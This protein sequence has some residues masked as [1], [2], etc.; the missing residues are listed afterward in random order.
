MSDALSSPTRSQSSVTSAAHPAR[1]SAQLTEQNDFA[2]EI[3]L[4]E[5]EVRAIEDERE[6]VVHLCNSG[7]RV[8]PFRQCFYGTVSPKSAKFT[9]QEVSSVAVV[10]KNVPFNIWIEKIVSRLLCDNESNCQVSFSLPLYCDDFDEEKD[11]YPFVEFLWTPQCKNEQV[12]GG[13]LMTRETPWT[14]SECSVAT[15]LSTLHLH[16]RAALKGQQALAPRR[17][18]LKPALLGSCA[19]ALALGFLPVSVTALAPTEVLPKEPFVLAAPFDGVVTE[20][21]ATQGANVAAGDPVIIFDDVHLLSEKRLADQ[22]AAIAEARYQRASQGAIADHRVKREIEVA[23]A[24]Y[25]L[26]L[27]ES[28]YATALLEK[29]RLAS[30]VPGIAIFS[31][32][33]DWEGKPVS[34]G[35]AIVSIADPGKVQFS[36]DLPVKDSIV[37]EKGA[38]VKIFLDSDPLNPL[39]AVLTDTSYRATPDKRDILSYGLRAELSDPDQTLPRIGVQGT[40]QVYSEKASLAYV[41]FRRPIAALRQY[42][43]W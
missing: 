10:D 15:R 22:R 1:Q 4:F 2:T 14:D 21:S 35:Q 33:R 26:A 5:D 32:K 6:L 17:A 28:S 18:V 34:A 12:L 24:E 19:L 20:I 25:Q 7:R 39:E 11:T 8:I 36:I 40:A 38:R 30:P 27:A 29:T 37:L 16:S 43:G 9:L 41:I 31:D 42:T 3:L 23:K 13:F